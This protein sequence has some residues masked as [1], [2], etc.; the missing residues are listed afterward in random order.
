MKAFII[1]LKI[2][3]IFAANEEFNWV[4]VGPLKQAVLMVPLNHSDPNSELTPIALSK[5]SAGKQPSKKIVIVNPGG[6][7]KSGTEMVNQNGKQLAEMFD[8]Q[9]DII[10]F[11][12]RGTDRNPYKS[13]LKCMGLFQKGT[14]ASNAKTFGASFLPKHPNVAQIEYLDASSQLSANLCKIHSREFLSFTSTVHVARDM[15]LLR[16]KLGMDKMNFFGLSYGSVLG[17]TYSN[18]F[19]DNVGHMILD[20]ISNPE[21]YT[22]DIFQYLNV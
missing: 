11:D 7:G 18:M 2:S 4:G 13:P 16:Q 15:E 6:P 22:G 14:Y 9:M 20:G 5:Y 3:F 1:L 8:N 19:P 17:M 12:S 10:G 21:H